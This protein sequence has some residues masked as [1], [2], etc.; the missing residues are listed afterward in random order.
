M[1]IWQAIV[2]GAVQ[3]FAEFLPISS[4]GHLML[5]QNWFGITE[6]AFFFTM[7][8]HLATLIPVVIVLWKQILGLFKK[9]FNTFWCL[10]LATIPAGVVGL[11]MSLLVDIDS[12]FETNIWILGIIFLLTAGEM[13]YAEYRAKKVPMVNGINAKTSFIM[14]CGQAC[15]VVP[16]LSRSGTTIAFGCLAN[17]KK[18]ENANFTFLMSIPVILMAVVLEIIK[19]VTK[20]EGFGTIEVLPLVFGMVTAMVCGYVAITFMLKLIKKANYKWF[21]LYLVLISIATFVTAFV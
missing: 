5:I 17:V 16:G 15:G 6:G 2:L 13:L 4:S 1:E 7:M 14:G 20:P 9:P 11:A 19:G 8:L 3:G 12:F 10:V 18:E 21:S